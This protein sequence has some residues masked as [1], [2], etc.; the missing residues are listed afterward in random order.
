MPTGGGGQTDSESTLKS[1]SQ[2]SFVNGPTALP[3]NSESIPAELKALPQ[4]LGWKL[5]LIDGRNTKVPYQAKYPRRKASTTKP[6]TWATFDKALAAYKRGE[7]D[8]IGFVPLGTDPYTA[9]D[10]DKCR[11]KVTGELAPRAAEIVKLF[12]SYTEVSPSGTGIRIFVKGRLKV[13]ADGEPTERT[14][15]KAGDFEVY[16]GLTAKR[17]Q[18]GRYLTM[19]GHRLNEFDI[20]ERQAELEQVYDEKF[21]PKEPEKNKAAGVRFTATA[22]GDVELLE[23]IRNSK[24]GPKFKRLWAG[25][26]SEYATDQNDGASEADQALCNILA[27]WTNRDAERI[28]RLFSLSGLN[29][30]KWQERDDYRDRTIKNALDLVKEGYSPGAKLQAYDRLETAYA[31]TEPTRPLHLFKNTD[32]GNAE[33]L[34]DRHGHGIRYCHEVG[35]FVWDEKR[36]RVDPSG[37]E[38]ERR[39]KETIRAGYVEA[40][41]I[42][43]DEVRRAFIEFL[44]RSENRSRISAM[45][46][47]VRSE[48]GMAVQ[49]NDF[50]RDPYFLNC[51]NGTVDLRTGQLRPHR[52]EDLITQLV[53]VEYD[54]NATCPTWDDFQAKISGG[55]SELVNFKQKAFGYALTG[56]TLE[57]VIFICFGTGANGKSTEL[58]VLR[59]MLGDFAKGT[60]F[61]SFEQ[62]RTGSIRND[63]AR[64]RGARFV[65]AVES[66]QGSSLSESVVKS[67]TG[68]DSITARFLHRE[69]FEFT[70][71]FT[72]FLATNHK[73]RI[74]GTDHGIWR[75][76][77]LI[78][79]NVT[80]P[81]AEQDKCLRD[82]LTAELPGVLA[83]AVQGC[84][85]WQ[86]DGLT[87]PESV[88][89]ATEMYREEMD[90]LADFL[91][92]Y[93]ETGEV[94]TVPKKDIR[95]LYLHHCKESGNHAMSTG[96]LKQA[97]LERGYS[98]GRTATERFWVGLGLSN[99][100]EV[101][102]QYHRG[103]QVTVNPFRRERN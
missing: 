3:V 70:P 73:P 10:I 76:I 52:R 35:F 102:L 16:D 49:I 81:T 19:T 51:L 1:L 7:F 98:E 5:E 23:L 78:P 29:R 71:T 95:D 94:L 92:E 34:K 61:S 22:P 14:R 44:V 72:V 12:S 79:Y 25:D 50:D 11:D 55:S 36:W 32:M 13:T 64:L 2:P 80:I 43:N 47:L 17:E 15:S 62:Q 67:L 83:W 99:A 88:Q 4:W 56:T 103:P 41:T 40:A 37:S 93:F 31:T 75:R 26:T 45:T 65:T 101:A 97:L 87:P 89:A 54:P 42:D 86:Q 39:A 84:L 46:E 6:A 18:G 63:L 90:S 66:D 96:A 100:G 33:R 74:K 48:P 28:H 27:F 53:P 30:D 9:L 85:A 77:R 91:R 58:E 57:Q 38:V 82:K 20:E 60:E 68:G 69:Y 59:E 24:Q 21:A 8:G